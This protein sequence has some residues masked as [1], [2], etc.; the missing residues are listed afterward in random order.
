MSLWAW[1]KSKWQ[2]TSN[3][4]LP[5]EQLPEERAE[6]QHFYHLNAP[7]EEKEKNEKVEEQIRSLNQLPQLEREPLAVQG[8][9]ELL[10]VSGPVCNIVGWKDIEH[11]VV[12]SIKVPIGFKKKA[13]EPIKVYASVDK[14]LLHVTDT[15]QSMNSTIHVKDEEGN[16]IGDITCNGNIIKKDICGELRVNAVLSGFEA[17]RDL[18]VE[19]NNPIEDTESTAFTD[20]V[21]VVFD[22][23]VGYMCEDCLSEEHEPT[24]TLTLGTPYVVLPDG[25]IVQQDE[26]ATFRAFNEAPS[27]TLDDVLDGKATYMISVPCNIL[28]KV[29]VDI[30]S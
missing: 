19:N 8:Q 30:Y 6:M 18:K 25:T 29:E 15:T 21:D 9:N 3:E 14:S 5:K 24:I 11:D 17:I 23:T 1:I 7:V 22:D 12:L 4:E 28:V 20:L 2:K 10:A 13:G 16:E 27:Q 26:V